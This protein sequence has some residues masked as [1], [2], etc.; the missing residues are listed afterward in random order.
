MAVFPIFLDTAGSITKGPIPIL[1]SLNL[2]EAYCV[3]KQ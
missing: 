1:N 3:A 2:I